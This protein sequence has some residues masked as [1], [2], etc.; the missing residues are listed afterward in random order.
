MITRGIVMRC[1]LP[2]GV[3]L[4]IAS[5]AAGSGA[6]FADEPAKAVLQGR[7]AAMK[8]AM[9]A[10][11]AAAIERMLA[12]GFVSIDVTGQ[13]ESGTQM[14]AEVIALKSDPNKSS[15][16]TLLSVV[17]TVSGVTVEQRYDMKTVKSDADGTPHDIELVALSTDTWVKSADIWLIERSVTNEL[18]LFRDGQLVAHKQRP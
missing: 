5:I 10:H 15:E 11:D 18:S 6:G 9:A 7:Y 13:P 3:A 12:P 4:S 14:I 1:L 16:T 8:M 17:R 2:F